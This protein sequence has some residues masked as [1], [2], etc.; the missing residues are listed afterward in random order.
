[1]G[2]PSYDPNRLVRFVL[3]HSLAGVMGGWTF[4]LA[5]LWL[6]IGGVGTLVRAAEQ[7]E[8]IT[9]MMAGAFGVTFGLVGLAWGVLVV[10]PESGDERD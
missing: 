1:M 2:R 8:L 6:D 4:L 7:R 10:L 9:A 3:R 5:L